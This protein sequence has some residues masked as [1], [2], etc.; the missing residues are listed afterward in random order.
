MAALAR[1]GPGPGGVPGALVCALAILR[2]RPG[3]LLPIDVAVLGALAA[4]D[5]WLETDDAALVGRIVCVCGATGRH[6][7]TDLCGVVARD[8]LSVL[9]GLVG[10]EPLLLRVAA[11]LEIRLWGQPTAVRLARDALFPAIHPV[12]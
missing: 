5:D 7:D 10:G 6:G 2:Q 11:V 9:G 4:T 12:H 3:R 1:T 8:Q